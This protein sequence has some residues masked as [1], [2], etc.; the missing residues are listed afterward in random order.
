MF[1][2]FYLSLT[3]PQ[4][5]ALAARAGTTTNYIRT[6]LIAPARRRKTPNK[7]LMNDL[8][9]ACTEAGAPFDKAQLLEY[10]YEKSVA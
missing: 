6:H 9:I 4:R 5:E 2:D 1:K 3:D 7:D 8:A 10:F